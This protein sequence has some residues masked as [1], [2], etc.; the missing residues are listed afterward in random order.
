[1]QALSIQYD[2]LRKIRTS[3][4]GIVFEELAGAFAQAVIRIHRAPRV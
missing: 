2:G 4:R 1:M 3:D